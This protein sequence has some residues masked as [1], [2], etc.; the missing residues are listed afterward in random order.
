MRTASLMAALLLIYASAFAQ[1]GKPAE[2]SSSAAPGSARTLP[3]DQHGGMTLSA[4]PYTDTARA[5]EKFER[6]G[7]LG[8][9]ILPVGV[10]LRNDTAQ[11]I[12][13][14][15]DTIQL[16]LEVPGNGHQ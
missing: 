15:L 10:F 7:P 12:H 4:D 11:P 9:G 14:D 3:R 13:I 6:A 2:N 8:A 16:E 1:A 5:K